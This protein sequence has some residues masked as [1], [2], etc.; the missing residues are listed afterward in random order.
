MA[1][2]DDLLAVWHR[3]IVANRVVAVVVVFRHEVQS[4]LI[5]TL[6]ILYIEQS[7]FHSFELLLYL[8]LVRCYYV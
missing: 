5:F 2:G 8:A 4:I 1:L 6:K 7:G 3:L